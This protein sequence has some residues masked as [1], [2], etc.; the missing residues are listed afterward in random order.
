VDA[1]RDVSGK[2]ESFFLVATTFGNHTL[3]HLFPTVDQVT[4]ELPDGIFSYQNL[5]FSILFEAME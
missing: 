5:N 2:S 1:T 4:A 3:H